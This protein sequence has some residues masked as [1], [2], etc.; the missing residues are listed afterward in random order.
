MSFP[1]QLQGFKRVNQGDDLR[2]LR[3]ENLNDL[4]KQYRFKLAMENGKPVT[5]EMY[6]VVNFQIF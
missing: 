4:V 2:S 6:V 3:K 5:V 1:E